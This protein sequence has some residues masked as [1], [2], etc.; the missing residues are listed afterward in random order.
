MKDW[1]ARILSTCI[2]QNKISKMWPISHVTAIL[3]PNDHPNDAESYR[4]I[5]LALE[6]KVQVQLSSSRAAQTRY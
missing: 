4:P 5:H 1:L 3:Q 6:G 2:A